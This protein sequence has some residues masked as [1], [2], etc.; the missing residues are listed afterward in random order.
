MR[1]VAQLLS[2]LV[3]NLKQATRVGGMGRGKAGDPRERPTR[4]GRSG[5]TRWKAS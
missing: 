5:R 4:A 1:N 2:A 3:Q